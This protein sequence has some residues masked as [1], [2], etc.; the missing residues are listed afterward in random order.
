MIIFKPI[1]AVISFFST[2]VDCAMDARKMHT[3]M[4]KN[5]RGF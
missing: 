4:L 3:E 1:L 5:Y 2:L